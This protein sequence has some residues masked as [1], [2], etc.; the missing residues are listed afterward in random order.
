MKKLLF[1]FLVIIALTSCSTTQYLQVYSVKTPD[2]AAMDSTIVFSD[3]NCRIVYNFWSNGGTAGFTI[4]NSSNQF[5]YVDLA[6]SFFVRNMEVF[7]YFQN[8]TFSYSENISSISGTGNSGQ[9]ISGL[10]LAKS[11]SKSK[12]TTIREQQIIVLPPNTLKTVSVYDINSSFIDFCDLNK[13]PGSKKQKV[14]TFSNLNSPIQFCNYISYNLQNAENE[15][16]L[17]HD[18]YVN[19]IYNVQEREVLKA[20]PLIKCGK[21]TGQMVYTYTIADSDKFYI[22][23]NS[24]GS[25][26]TISF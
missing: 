13:K 24:G 7:P 6:K 22:R 3:E 2:N 14:L 18:F 5:L 11:V 10:N 16:V 12:E 21:R 25:G 19:E 26:F 15:V 23:Y 8:R 17:K 1:L 20:S 4:Y 9:T